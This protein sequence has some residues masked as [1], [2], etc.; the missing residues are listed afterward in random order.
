M[1]KAWFGMAQPHPIDQLGPLGPAFLGPCWTWAETKPSFKVRL[2]LDMPQA[3]PASPMNTP[4]LRPSL[5]VYNQ[6]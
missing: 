5:L 6:M 3:G 4:R 2:S 1:Y